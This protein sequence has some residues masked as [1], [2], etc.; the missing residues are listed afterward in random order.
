[1]LPLSRAISLG[2]VIDLTSEAF[3]LNDISGLEE[4]G[5]PLGITLIFHSVGQHDSIYYALTDFYSARDVAELQEAG[6][7][8]GITLVKPKPETL[9]S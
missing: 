1:M 2:P 5:N 8:L 7:P 4:S 3:H 6:S 9:N